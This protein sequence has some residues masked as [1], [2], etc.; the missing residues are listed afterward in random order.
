MICKRYVRAISSSS[1]VNT[2]QHCL[3]ANAHKCTTCSD[4]STEHVAEKQ[5]PRQLDIGTCCACKTFV[6]TTTASHCT[7]RQFPLLFQKL[8]KLCRIKI[9]KCVVC[10]CGAT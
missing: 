6:I 2:R 7:A 1:T 8:V 3:V 5:H 4:K 9:R 10:G